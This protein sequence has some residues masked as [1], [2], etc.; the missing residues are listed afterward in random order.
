MISFFKKTG[1]AIARAIFALFAVFLIA[2]IAVQLILITGINIVSTGRGTDFI[3]KKINEALVDSGYHVALDALYYDPVRGFTIHDL[4]VS[5]KEGAFLSLDRFSLSVSLARSPLKTLSLSGQGGTLSVS[6]I[7]VSEA[8]TMQENPGGMTPFNVP[9][10]YFT[11]I[12]LSR[13]SFDHVLLGEAVTGKPYALSPSIQARIAM[14]EA[15]DIK[16]QF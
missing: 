16:M 4:S 12:I 8:P 5:D 6:R 10:I 13:L 15:I 3:S 7:P 2:L 1:L 14:S 9:N 11:K